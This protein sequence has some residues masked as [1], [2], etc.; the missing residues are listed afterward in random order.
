MRRIH[1]YH[2]FIAGV[3]LSALGS[4]AQGAAAYTVTDLGA[5]GDSWSYGY[6]INSH[7][8][9]TGR[10]YAGPLIGGGGRAFLHDGAM[11]DLGTLGG[12]YSSGIAINDNGFVTGWSDIAANG[13]RHAFLYD[14][15]MHDLGTLGGSSSIGS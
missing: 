3:L 7:G 5:L 11:H 10:S 4:P 13:Q 15:V 2:L 14:G 12:P 8:H 6:G 9:V 1:T